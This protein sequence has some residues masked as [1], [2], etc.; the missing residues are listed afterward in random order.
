MKSILT[1]LRRSYHLEIDAPFLLRVDSNDHQFQC[2]IRGYGAQQGMVVDAEWNKIAPIENDLIAMGFGYSC[3][4]I[5]KVEV[6]GF[7]EILDD[8]GK[9]KI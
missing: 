8:W 5:E 4:D 6:D 2:R 7:Q 3:F 9:S 1:K